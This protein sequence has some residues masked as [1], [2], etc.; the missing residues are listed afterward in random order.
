[1]TS[2]LKTFREYMARLDAAA[3][4]E[5]ALE[6]GFY[7]ERPGRSVGKEITDRVGLRPASTH[8]LVGG[9]GS[10]KTTQLLVACNQLNE[11]EDTWAKYIDVSETYDLEM[12]RPGALL[13]LAECAL[14]G[15]PDDSINYGLPEQVDELRKLHARLAQEKPHQ[16]IFFDSLDRL[17]DPAMFEQIAEH[18][19]RVIRSIGIG[20]VVAGPL[21]ALYGLDRPIADRFDYFYHQPPVDVQQDPDGRSFLVSILR[22]RL[23]AKV[24][25][26]D[27]CF[28]LAAWSGGVLRDLVALAQSACE[29]AYVSGSDTITAAE[30]D[31]AADA[32]GRKHLLG[33]G[34]DEI[35]VL[36]RVRKTGNFIQASEKD[37]ALLVTRRVLEYSGGRTRYAVHPTLEPLLAQLATT[38]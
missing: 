20:V 6:R 9:V 26:D 18:V 28:R 19:I 22:A 16:T 25:P 33:L 32:F 2:R 35:E 38:P 3:N 17:A 1:M 7:V 14:G 34:P 11:L 36:Q 27:T 12:L 21:R 5:R 13:D 24:L 29:E 30:A 4:P 15:M 8:L 10:G 31:R 37:L 23:S